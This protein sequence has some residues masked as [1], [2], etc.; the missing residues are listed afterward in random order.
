MTVLLHPISSPPSWPFS[1]T[2]HLHIGMLALIPEIECL[3]W[4]SYGFKSLRLRV[5][6][7]LVETGNR[8]GENT[9]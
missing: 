6:V 1:E 8:I 2:S 4:L 7:R 9:S 5:R 3:G